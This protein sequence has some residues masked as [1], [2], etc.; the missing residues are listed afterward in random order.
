MFIYIFREYKDIA[1]LN[2]GTILLRSKMV[3]DSIIVLGAA[4]DHEANSLANNFI[5]ANAYAVYGDYN[6]SIEH[7]DR[8]LI[9]DPTYA[10]T[11]KHRYGAL[12]HRALS[13]RMLGI[14]E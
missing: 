3:N 8:C 6:S 5:L 4:F 13:D 12:C 11:E 1:L 7:Y 9:L 2:M 10:L 14:R